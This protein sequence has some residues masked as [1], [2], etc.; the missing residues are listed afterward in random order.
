[1]R[2]WTIMHNTPFTDM[3]DSEGETQVVGYEA[4]ATAHRVLDLLIALVPALSV[5]AAR[6]AENIRRSCA[7]ITELADS[8]VRIEGLSF[9]QAHEIAAEGRQGRD[10]RR[11]SAGD[12]TA[13][14][15]PDV[16]RDRRRPRDQDRRRGIRRDR[17][18]R[19]FHRR[20]RPAG[21]PGDRRRWR[22]RWRTIVAPSFASLSEIADGRRAPRGLRR[23]SSSLPPSNN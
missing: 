13:M 8:L 2:C 10:R 19:T 6:V 11:R 3:N 7:T 18:G 9:R 15:L 1:M 20:A 5:N 16:L 21:R 22:T 12:A 23:R 17:L 4:F 14:R